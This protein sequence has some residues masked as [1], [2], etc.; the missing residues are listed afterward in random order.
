MLLDAVICRHN[1]SQK[2]S[3]SLDQAFNQHEVF[4]ASVLAEYNSGQPIVSSKETLETDADQEEEVRLIIDEKWFSLSEL[5]VKLLGNGQDGDSSHPSNKRWVIVEGDFV[6]HHFIGE[7]V[8][9]CTNLTACG[10]LRNLFEST[11]EN[12]CKFPNQAIFHSLPTAEKVIAVEGARGNQ[13]EQVA[14]VLDPATEESKAMA[15][16]V[17]E[18]E[19]V[20]RPPINE[21]KLKIICAAIYKGIQKYSS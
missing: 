7:I 19:E 2:K 1:R 4:R 13:S 8:V 21:T 15:P 6:F 18:E 14:A 3:I 5:R 17:D 16:S 11:V 10:D 9:L 20:K 12:I